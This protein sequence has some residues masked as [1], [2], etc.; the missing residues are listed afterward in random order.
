MKASY[1][2]T[3]RIETREDWGAWLAQW[4]EHVTLDCGAVGLSPM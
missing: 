3:M 2:G 4:I 1:I